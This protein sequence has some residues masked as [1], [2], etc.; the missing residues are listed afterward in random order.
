MH[1]TFCLGLA[2]KT[3]ANVIG[4]LQW[5]IR[6]HLSALTPLPHS[7]RRLH[8]QQHTWSPRSLKQGAIAPKCWVFRGH[9]PLNPVQRFVTTST[10][11][12]VKVALGAVVKCYY[13]AQAYR[14]VSAQTASIAPA[15]AQGAVP[16]TAAALPTHAWEQ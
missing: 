14:T 2:D 12:R 8:R 16:L 15:S 13:P 11:R 7:I 4:H 10:H 1:G 6:D 9:C 5:V 3:R